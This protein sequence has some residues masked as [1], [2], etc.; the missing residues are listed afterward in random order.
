MILMTDGR[1]GLGGDY[2]EL[3]REMKEGRISLSTVAIGS[4]ADTG[5]LEAMARAGRGRY[6]FTANPEDIP[7]IFTRETLMATRTLMV[8]NRF[9]PAVASSSPLLRGL[10][11]V[12]PLDGYVATTS[13]EQA[14]VVLVSPDGDPVLAAWQYGL[15]RSAAWTPDVGGRWSGA[16]SGNPVSS[17]L[18][19][20]LL[21][22]LLPPRE[23]GELS[24]KVD[25]AGEGLL[26]VVAEN[27]SGWEEI[28]PTRATL[29]TPLGERMELELPPAGPGRYQTQMEVPASGAYVIQV[30]QLLD[31][32]GELR[33]ESGWVAPYPAEYREMGV[34]RALLARIVEAGGGRV[35]DDPIQAV[36]PARKAATAR[37]PVSPLLLVLAALFWPLEIASRR[38]L[39]PAAATW[40]PIMARR[41]GGREA[42]SEGYGETRMHGDAETRRETKEAALPAAQ[43]TER[44]LE[45]KRALREK[46]RTRARVDSGKCTE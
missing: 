10:T 5:L 9:Y 2:G 17:L 27:R 15:G 7:Q 34:D 44:L 8:N 40:L 6:H 19:G 11:A 21:S 41:R 26:A 22:W 12:P 37:W 31:G 29:L 43:T 38:L 25:S 28:R 16:W 3:V 46:Q 33:G 18:W 1:S 24:V 36:E 13:K 30:S 45:R 42:G 32:G 20:N 39:I 4:D 35:L 23:V 14:E